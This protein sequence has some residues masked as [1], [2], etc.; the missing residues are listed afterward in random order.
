MDRVSKTTRSRIMSCVRSTGNKSTEARLR[1][2]LANSGI[3][4]WQVRPAEPEGK[5]D[6][7]FDV[8]RVAV[9]VDGAFW[10]GAPGFTRF[11]KSRAHYWKP[12]IERNRQRDREVTRR[13]RAQGWA[14]LRFW[15]YEL[16][17]NPKMVVKKIRKKVQQ[18]SNLQMPGYVPPSFEA[19]SM[20][21]SLSNRSR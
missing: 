10:H 17:D 21:Y 20:C 1:A 7:V 13:L 16:Q 12:K 14:V 11:P 6:F 5:P 4:G 19:D 15:D 3:R 18:R 9:F 8:A 2:Y